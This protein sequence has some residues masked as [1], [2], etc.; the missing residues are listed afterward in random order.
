MHRPQADSN[1]EWD[2]R[3]L[4][5]ALAVNG[6]LSLVQLAGGWWANSLALIADAL[7]NGADAAAL[8]IAFYALRLARR[9]ADR[10]RTFGYRRAETVAALINLVVLL[11]VG[12]GLFYEAVWR[13]LRPE[14]VAGDWMMILGALALAVD[15]ATVAVLWQGSR[16]SLNL[17][18]AMLH[19]AADALSSLGVLAGGAAIALTGRAAVDA[20]LGMAIGVWVAY[21]AWR[22]LPETIHILMNGAPDHLDV[23]D[24][25]AALAAEPQVASVHHLHLWRLDE[26]RDALEAHVVVRRADLNDIE[27]IKGRL[28]RLLAERYRIAHVTLEIETEDS[29]CPGSTA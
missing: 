2:A 21:H 4:G 24:I 8:A 1:R 18:A 5:W 26:Q 10:R 3:R 11:L 9:P 17:R 20:W 29:P 27:A 22:H 12:A 23:D 6:L 14:P 7:H 28:K 25:A 13:L 15:L 16:R 19:N